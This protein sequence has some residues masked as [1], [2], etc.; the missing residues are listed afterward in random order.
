MWV[1]MF[2]LCQMEAEFMNDFGGNNLNQWRMAVQK[3]NEVDLSFIVIL[4]CNNLLVL[5]EL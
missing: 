4:K 1:S 3:F 2:G 5:T